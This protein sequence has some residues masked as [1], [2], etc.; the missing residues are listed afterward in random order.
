MFGHNENRHS[1]QLLSERNLSIVFL[2]TIVFF[3]VEI[4]G[5][6][7]SNS[8]ALFADSIHMLQDIIALGMSVVAVK[9]VKKAKR[10][11]PHIRL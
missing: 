6:I 1:T 11:T 5:S 10:Q 8:L 3:F 7:L 2:L 9:L 4:A